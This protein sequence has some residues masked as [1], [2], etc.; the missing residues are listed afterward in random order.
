MVR[1]QGF[2]HRPRPHPQQ[3][4]QT[5]A[6]K[7]SVFWTV[8]RS[9][10]CFIAGGRIWS[11]FSPWPWGPADTPGHQAQ[12]PT[13]SH[14][15]QPFITAPVR[16][17]VEGE[18]G[19]T[20]PPARKMFASGPGMC[21]WT[22]PGPRFGLP[23]RQTLAGREVQPASARSASPGQALGPGLGVDTLPPTFATDPGPGPARDL[24]IFFGVL[25]R[26]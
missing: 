19:R 1:T 18:R 5:T 20:L 22:A 13:T 3:Q 24:R 17:S 8:S 23:G 21:P 2:Q 9:C 11:S 4:R 26:P 15:V 10:F 6:T 12:A 7:S 25:N 16:G 14:P